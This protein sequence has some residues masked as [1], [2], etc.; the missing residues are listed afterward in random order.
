MT[1]VRTGVEGLDALTGGGLP[2]ETVTLVSGPAGSGKSLLCLHFVCQ[3]AVMEGEPSLYISLEESAE[4][5]TRALSSYRFYGGDPGAGGRLTIMDMGWLRQ[6]LDTGGSRWGMARLDTIWREGRSYLIS[7]D[8]MREEEQVE[9]ELE[10]G[11]VGFGTLEAVVNHFCAERGIR[12]LVIDS[13]AAVG[14]YYLK[15]EELRR[16][17]FRF[18]RFLRDRGLATMV[19]TESVTGVP[20]QTRYGVEHFIADTHIVLGMRSFKGEARR[21]ILIQK[22]RFGSHDGGIHP[23]TITDAGIDVNTREYIRF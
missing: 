11:M 14:L 13:L 17:L 19:V 5:V 7:T 1:K 4:S 22:M 23:F 3:G 2:L 10:A 21:T 12:R 16:E 8:W 9:R 18:G 20:G 6:Q 15:P